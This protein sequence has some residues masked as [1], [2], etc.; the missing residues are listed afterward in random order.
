M[1]WL[2]VE[3]SNVGL[4]RRQISRKKNDWRRQRLAQNELN[5]WTT[6]S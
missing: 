1:S 5:A 3:I 4:L 2:L 6:P